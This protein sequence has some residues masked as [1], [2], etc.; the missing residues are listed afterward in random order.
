M[1]GGGEW[2]LTGF[3]SPFTVSPR[4]R[5]GGSLVGA[6]SRVSTRYAL[7]VMGNRHAGGRSRLAVTCVWVERSASIDIEAGS[8]ELFIY[9]SDLE[10]LPK[11]CVFIV[12]TAVIHASENSAI[13]VPSVVC[14]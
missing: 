8:E 14:R 4:E 12:Y 6:S 7:P 11:W 10:T 2:R 5:Q 9:Y 1:K 3:V 13:S